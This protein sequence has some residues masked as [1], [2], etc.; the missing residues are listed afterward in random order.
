M[1]AIRESI[2]AAL[3]RGTRHHQVTHSCG[4]TWG[5]SFPGTM[6]AEAV[7]AALDEMRSFPC[8]QHMMDELRCGGCSARV[9]A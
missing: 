8:P 1:S 5:A 7:E 2:A 6:P 3:H 9:E 4:C